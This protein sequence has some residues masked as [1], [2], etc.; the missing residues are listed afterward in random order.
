MINRTSI[1]TSDIDRRYE[2]HL[3]GCRIDCLSMS[4]DSSSNVVEILLP[5]VL[6]TAKSILAISV[7]GMPIQC[8]RL[9][10]VARMPQRYAISPVGC[11]AKSTRVSQ[12]IPYRFFID[13][14]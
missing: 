6:E 9:L 4:H 14:S 12:W 2:Q 13:V 8:G 5:F 3:N 10:I 7:V 11:M 1:L